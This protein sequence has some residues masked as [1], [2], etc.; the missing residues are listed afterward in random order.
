M[1]NDH[2]TW[3]LS[4]STLATLEA[5]AT[6][7][8]NAVSVG[9]PFVDGPG[10]TKRA[11]DIVIQGAITVRIAAIWRDVLPKLEI[12]G[13]VAEPTS[14]LGG[15]SRRARR[16]LDVTDLMSDFLGTRHQL[17]VIGREHSLPNWA[18][19]IASPIVIEDVIAIV[20]PSG[21]RAFIAPDREVPGG[22][23]LTRTPED[24]LETIPIAYVRLM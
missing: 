14:P 5:L 1:G 22:I 21:Q 6:G 12:F 16:Q 24:L 18:S 13:L 19:S 8:W 2:L 7:P 20:S 11:G 4:V 23:V 15:D 10:L 9:P 3:S 17:S